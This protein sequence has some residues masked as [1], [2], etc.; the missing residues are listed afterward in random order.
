MCLNSVGVW[1]GDFGSL[2]DY[3]RKVGLEGYQSLV[4][5]LANEFCGGGCLGGTGQLEGSVGKV[6]QM[7][8]DGYQSLADS[9]IAIVSELGGGWLGDSRSMKDYVRKVGQV[10]Q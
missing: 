6:G 1:L 7:Q 4:M 8:D 5:C 9:G 2:K 10:Q 3:V